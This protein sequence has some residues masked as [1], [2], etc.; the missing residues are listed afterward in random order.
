MQ[1]GVRHRRSRTCSAGSRTARDEESRSTGEKRR[2]RHRRLVRE[3]A[4]HGETEVL[5]CLG[6]RRDDEEWVVHRYLNGFPERSVDATAV[7]VIDAE[8][9]R[10]EEAVE[11]ASL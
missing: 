3:V 5:G 8:H 1:A 4:S 9:V 6:H 7:D 2:E 11:L 10:Q